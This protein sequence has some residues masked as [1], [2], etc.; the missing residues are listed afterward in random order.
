MNRR[1]QHSLPSSPHSSRL[2]S[3]YLPMNL[4]NYQSIITHSCPS[5]SHNHR[6]DTWATHPLTPPFSTKP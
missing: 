6:K 2:S 3:T 1:R 5:A 4:P